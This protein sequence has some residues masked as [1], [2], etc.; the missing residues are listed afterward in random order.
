[1]LRYADCVRLVFAL[2]A[3]ALP[4][5]VAPSDQCHNPTPGSI[6]MESPCSKASGPPGRFLVIRTR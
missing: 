5:L 1:M 2:R 3:V 6:P 4:S